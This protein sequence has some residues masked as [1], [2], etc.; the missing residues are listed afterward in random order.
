MREKCEERGMHIGKPI[1]RPS[2]Y[3]EDPRSLRGPDVSALVERTTSLSELQQ[4][5]LYEILIKYIDH[6]TTKPGRC[7]LL[8]YKFQV[9]TDKP[10]VGHS[11]PIPFALRPAIRETTKWQ[12]MLEVSAS[13]ILNPLTIVKKERGKIRICVDAR[14]VNQFTVPDRERVPPIQELLQKF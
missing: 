7:N 5:R 10:I 3:P 8:K 1:P 14:K 9:N 11:R 12:M 6:L 13:P 4:G 2:S